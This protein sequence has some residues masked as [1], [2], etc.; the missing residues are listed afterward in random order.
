[1]IMSQARIALCTM[2]LFFAPLCAITHA[3]AMM[4]ADQGGGYA[5]LILEKVSK[6]WQAPQYPSDHTVRI[7]VRIDGDGEVLSC[8]PVQSSNLALMDKSACAAVKEIKKY[9]PPPYGMPIDVYLTFWTGLPTVGNVP[10]SPEKQAQAAQ[11]ARNEQQASA[12]TASA[13]ALARAAEARAAAAAKGSSAKNV[14]NAPVSPGTSLAPRGTP[15]ATPVTM[16][17]STAPATKGS[18][19]AK[20]TASTAKDPAS[21]PAVPMSKASTSSKGSAATK[22]ASAGTPK[23]ATP[24]PAQGQ[25]ERAPAAPQGMVAQAPS[26]PVSQPAPAPPVASTPPVVE[27][28]TSSQ[29][30]RS[31]GQ[32]T[33]NLVGIKAEEPTASEGRYARQVR[34][35]I[36]EAMII[37]AELPMGVYT[38]TIYV[39]LSETGQ[40]I[41]ADLTHSSGDPLMDKYAMRG[42]KRV[43]QIPPPP[44]QKL[45]DLHLTFVVQRS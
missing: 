11:A 36:R 14:P 4:S 13:L 6:Q 20:A 7:Q 17:G 43:Q 32:P 28:I 9:P 24:S 8:T 18:A 30:P 16:A 23:G 29:N 35:T 25:P 31:T 44:T 26:A 33:G 2:A 38:F 12:A 21:Q 19:K 10:P 42:I 39:K 15:P 22:D 45:R 5:G 27:G 3:A 1:M 40:I 37:P 41:K 34:W